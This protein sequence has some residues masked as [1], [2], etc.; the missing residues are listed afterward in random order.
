MYFSNL[1][2][3]NAS[4]CKTQSWYGIFMAKKVCPK[5][6]GL[7]S[8]VQQ[9]LKV[10]MSSELYYDLNLPVPVL[11]TAKGFNPSFALILLKM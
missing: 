7:Y 4:A 5:S 8:N 3:R 1:G 11:S 10:E 6:P 2:G 9:F